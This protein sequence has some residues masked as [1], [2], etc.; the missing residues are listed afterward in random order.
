M[1]HADG[2]HILLSFFRPRPLLGAEHALVPIT[3][4]PPN[5]AV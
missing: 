2:Y 4:L 1:I 5:H 3:C